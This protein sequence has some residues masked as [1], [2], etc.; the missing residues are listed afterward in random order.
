MDLV[1]GLSMTSTALRWVVVEGT[2]GEG[3]MRDRGTVD[4]TGEVDPDELLEVLP[5]H[6]G[7]DRIHA[8]GVT[9]TNE[10]EDAASGVLAALTARGYDDIITVSELEA[11]E[12]LADGI[13]AITEYQT[14]AV[15][16]AEPDAAVVAMVGPDETTSDRIGRPRDGHDVVELPSSVLATLELNDWQPQAIFVLG[17]ADNLDM[18]IST[19]DDATESPVISATDADLAL[20]RGAALAAAGAVNSLTSARFRM[21]SRIGALT[22]IVAGAAVVFVVSLSAAIGLGLT[23]GDNGEQPQA[24][25][26]GATAALPP[27]PPVTKARLTES[28]QAARPL[29]AQTMVVAAPPA[30]EIYLPSPEPPA[31]APIAPAAPPPAYTQP[32]PAYVPPVQKPRLRDRILERIPIINRFHEPQPR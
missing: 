1:I 26:T 18:I 27:P 12:V 16:I 30:P 5:V 24:A 20:T 7:D 8:V 10:A 15:C 4:L 23:P 2:T 31:A 29:V 11:T 14:V 3:A 13:A 9:W 25:D 28:L 22:S 32:A 17:S 6:Q 21:P 19:I